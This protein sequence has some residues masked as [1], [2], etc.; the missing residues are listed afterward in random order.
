MDL[1]PLRPALHRKLGIVRRR[2]GAP[3]PALQAFMTALE[4]AARRARGRAKP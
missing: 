1:I 4:I 3:R 2:E